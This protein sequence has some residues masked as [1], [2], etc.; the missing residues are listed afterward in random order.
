METITIIVGKQ[1]GHTTVNYIVGG[2]LAPE[3]AAS[4]CRYIAGLFDELAWK[5]V[6]QRM[7][8]EIERRVAVALEEREGEIDAEVQRRLAGIVGLVQENAD[9]SAQEALG[10]VESEGKNADSPSD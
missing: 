4:A 8:A 9:S 10:R 1:D 2:N 6:E 7:E 5:G 3:R